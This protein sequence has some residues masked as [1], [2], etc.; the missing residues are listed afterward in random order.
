MYVSESEVRSEVNMKNKFV[1]H[2]DV[3]LATPLS[4]PRPKHTERLH[5][6]GSLSVRSEL[7]DPVGHGP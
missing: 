5:F 1:R 4:I 6:P 7:C 3:S 2:N